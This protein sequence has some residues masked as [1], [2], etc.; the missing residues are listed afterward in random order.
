MEKIIQ[1]AA[2]MIEAL[3]F[4]QQFR[5]ETVVVKFGGSIM[6]DQ[7]ACRAILQDVAFMEVVGLRPV[8]VHGG[9]KA[10][11][12]KMQEVDLKPHFHHGL[13]V[14]DA[15][16]MA[17][18]EEALNQT[19]NPA[20]VAMVTGFNCRA[21]GMH[22]Q[23]ILTSIKHTDI[24]PETGE[25]MDWGFVGEVSGV[26]IG[27]IEAATGAQSVPVITPIARGVDGNQYNINAD[28]AAAAIARALKARKLVFLSDV[29][30]VLA[31]PGDASSIITHIETGQVEPLIR[32]GVLSGGMIPKM[33]SAVKTLESGVRK[34]HI[35]DS[36]LRH[37]L[38]LELFTTR[39]VGTEIV[40]S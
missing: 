8:V 34:V 13:R 38:L 3:P 25:E 12:R 27:P 17:V 4:I 37:S 33:R 21:V 20:M 31:D 2:G 26:D 1:K 22:G 39:G 32:D 28:E 14:T 19:V 7:E 10:I 36:A 30:G 6:E 18:V 15:A 40:A 29:P 24:D 23:D 11:S 5:N 9:G 16:G 35:I